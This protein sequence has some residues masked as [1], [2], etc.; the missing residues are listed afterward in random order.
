MKKIKSSI[1]QLKKSPDLMVNK[2][3]QS[4]VKGGIERSKIKIPGRPPK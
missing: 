2:D 3:Q 4:K 1:D